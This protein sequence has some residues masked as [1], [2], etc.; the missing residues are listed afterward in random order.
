MFSFYSAVDMK[1]AEIYKG[2]PKVKVDCTLTLNDENFLAL[3]TGQTTGQ[4]VI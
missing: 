4:K 2:E 1:N 3:A